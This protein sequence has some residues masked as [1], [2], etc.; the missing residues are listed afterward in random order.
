MVVMTNNI[1]YFPELKVATK[2]F[3]TEFNF[4]L[5]DQSGNKNNDSRLNEINKQKK[6]VSEK[7]DQNSER[8]N[9]L[10]S[11][12]NKLTNNADG[13]DYTIAVGSG[14]LAGMI[15]SFWVGDFDLE[16]GRKWG[17]EKVNKFV[18]KV[19]KL[20]GYKGEDLDGAIQSLEKGFGLASDSN[21]RELGGTLQH[22]LRDFAHHP[23]IVGMFFSLLTQFTG[24]SYGTDTNGNFISVKVSNTDLIGKDIPEKITFGVVH[25]FFHMVSD[26][27][28]SKATAGAGTGLPGPLLSLLKEISALPFFQKEDSS[29]RELSLLA[30][31]LYNGTLLG[32]RD[33]NGKLIPLRFDLRAEIGVGYELGRQAIPV[34]INECLVRSFYFIRRLLLELK[35][36]DVKSIKQLDQIELK[37]VLPFN[38]RTIARMLTI[39]TGTFTAIDLADATIRSAI[40]SGGNKALFLKEFILK[41]NFVG[42]GRF[43][44]AIGT[45]GVMEYKRNQARNERMPILSEQLHYLN[46]SVY[47]TQAAMWAAAEN[48]EKTIDAALKKMEETTVYYLD[49]YEKNAQSMK[50]ISSFKEGIDRNNPGLINEIVDF[51]Q[52]GKV[53]GK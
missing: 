17:S 27:A 29:T 13:L 1:V 22:H 12:I 42:V 15:D 53:D 33:E 3:E 24:M 18:L 11:E 47:Y 44:I 6:K 8:L 16:R 43:A 32:K 39:S 28:G 52:W 48:T 31:K 41:V 7:I 26:V 10:N 38:N 30:S 37:N 49:T 23:T 25:W 36:K 21:M 46:A 4:E 2:D 50:R 34:I 51:I 14:I 40:K 35:E 45:E 5:F 20:K 9:Q 19:A